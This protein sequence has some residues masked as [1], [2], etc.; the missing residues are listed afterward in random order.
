MHAFDTQPAHILVLADLRLGEL[1]LDDDPDAHQG[2]GD[3]KDEYGGK[4]G[5]HCNSRLENEFGADRLV[6]VNLPDDG[7]EGGC[8]G[9]YLDLPC[10]CISPE[11]NSVGHV[12]FLQG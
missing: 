11:R 3:G 4:Q 12:D 9:D 8:H 7:S 10:V 2:D 1:S 6:I 5:L